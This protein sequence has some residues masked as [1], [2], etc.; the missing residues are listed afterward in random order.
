MSR[1]AVFL[2][3]DG[4]V[5][6]DVGYP[7]DPDLVR[8]LPGAVDA[9]RTLAGEG[10]ALVLISNQSGIGRGLISPAQAA[11]VHDRV[12]AGLAEQGITLDAVRYCPHGPQDGCACRKPQPG[13]LLDAASE[14]DIDLARSFSVGDK[15]S[16]TEAGRR[17]GTRT[18]QLLGAHPAGPD[19]DVLARSW[20]EILDAVLRARTQA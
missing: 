9:L 20:A 16:D 13:M 3:R 2:D 4:T 15:P 10:F 6:E 5:I 11:A 17:A 18:I 12:V 8:F 1:R 14:L 19:A 7:R